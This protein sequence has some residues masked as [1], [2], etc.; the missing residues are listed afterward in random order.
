MKILVHPTHKVVIMERNGRKNM[1]P[2][3]WRNAHPDVLQ[4][5]TREDTREHIKLKASKATSRRTH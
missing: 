2:Y 5:A 1:A 3:A 4:T